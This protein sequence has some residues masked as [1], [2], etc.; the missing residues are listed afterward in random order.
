MLKNEKFSPVKAKFIDHK[1][2]VIT[3]ATAELRNDMR[4]YGI[5]YYKNNNPFMLWYNPRKSKFS[6]HLMGVKLEHINIVSC[7][8]LC[9]KELVR[10]QREF[11][12]MQEQT[13]TELYDTTP[14]DQ[15]SRK[16]IVAIFQKIAKAQ[17]SQQ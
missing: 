7:L 10:K 4:S 1:F 2:K 3:E 8:K 9:E 13:I 12:Q 16:K 14:I 11:A 17:K 15:W 6:A 5:D